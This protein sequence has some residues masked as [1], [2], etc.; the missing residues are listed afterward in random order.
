[1][2]Y[3]VW[4][5]VGSAWGMT[6]AFASASKRVGHAPPLPRNMA[7]FFR[8]ELSNFRTAWKFQGLPPENGSS[9]GQ[10]LVLTV[11]YVPNSLDG[12]LALSLSL[13][14]DDGEASTWVVF[15]SFPSFFI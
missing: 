15:L 4:W 2:V 7:Q 3:G 10:N 8:A 12:S 1:M 5:R 11:L 9:Q 6:D 14:R 13:E